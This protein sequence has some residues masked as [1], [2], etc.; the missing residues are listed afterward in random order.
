[1]TLGGLGMMRVRH[2]FIVV[3]K[4]AVDQGPSFPQLLEESSSYRQC[5]CPHNPSHIHSN[6][7]PHY[8]VCLLPLL[9]L[10]NRSQPLSARL[11]MAAHCRIQDRTTLTC[12]SG[13]PQTEPFC[14]SPCQGTA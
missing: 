6:K 1:K 11:A 4:A 12:F 9:S 10:E 7:L 14:I 5:R 13:H 2:I 8:S 3:P